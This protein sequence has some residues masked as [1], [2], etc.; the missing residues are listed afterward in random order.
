MCP[1]K[2]ILNFTKYFHL[3]SFVLDNAKSTKTV[4]NVIKEQYINL[5]SM[6]LDEVF[7]LICFVILV[8]LW[9][10]QRPRFIPG[11]ADVIESEDM[12]GSIVKIGAATPAFIMVLIVFALPKKNPFKNL[13]NQQQPAPGILTWEVIQHKL[14]WGVII[15]L[16]GGFALS[17]GVKVSGTFYI[18]PIK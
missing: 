6:R 11:W 5:G 8:C 3:F 1:L 10:F 13:S 4:Y 9:F 14:Q 17:K 2:C 18:I 15:L 12:E 7:M 16:G